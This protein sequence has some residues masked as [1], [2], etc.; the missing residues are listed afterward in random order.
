MNPCFPQT[1]L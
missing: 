1:E